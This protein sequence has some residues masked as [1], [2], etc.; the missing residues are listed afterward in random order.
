[1]TRAARSAATPPPRGTQPAAPRPHPD[2]RL[3]P[4]PAHPRC[5][6][7]DDIDIGKAITQLE[8]EAR[9]SSTHKVYRMKQKG[10][11]KKGRLEGG[12]K[13]GK[14]SGGGAP[15]GGKAAAGGRKGGGGGGK[16]GGR[17][18]RK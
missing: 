16:G 2:T 9:V 4:L 17:G 1:M 13:G 18:G 3:R 14:Q 12:G 7:T 11:N 8:S 5:C 6:P 15:P 10:A